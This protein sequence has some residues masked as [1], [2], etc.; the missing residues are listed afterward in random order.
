MVTID[1]LAQTVKQENEK[2]LPLQARGILKAAIA[3]GWQPRFWNGRDGWQYPVCDYDGNAIVLRWKAAPNQGDGNKYSFIPSKP[4]NPLANWYILPGTADAIT[5]NHGVCYLA[6]GEPSK[7]AYHAAGVHNVIATTAS[8]NTVP[9]NTIDVLQKLGVHRLLYPADKDQAGMNSAVKWREALRGSG[10]DYE[11]LQ[12]SDQVP[13][14]GDANDLWIALEFD[15]ILFRATLHNLSPLDLPAVKEQPKQEYTGDTNYNEFPE[16]FVNAVIKKVETLEGFTRWKSNGWGNFSSPFREDKTPSAGFNRLTL[17]YNDFA[18]NGMGIVEFANAIG[19]NIRNYSQKSK[20]KNTSKKNLAQLP[21]PQQPEEETL[22]QKAQRIKDQ[23]YQRPAYTPDITFNARYVSEWASLVKTVK[24]GAIVCI[25]SKKNTGKTHAVD[26]V[27]KPALE[28]EK[29]ERLRSL[30]LGHLRKLIDQY[31]NEGTALSRHGMSKSQL[32]QSPEIAELIHS[33]EKLLNDASDFPEYDIIYW[34]EV[35]KGL[36][37]LISGPM[38]AGGKGI[39]IRNLLERLFKSAKYLYFTDAD[40]TDEVLQYLRDIAPGREII[41]VENEYVFDQKIPGQL[42]TSKR[43][44]LEAVSGDVLANPVKTEAIKFDSVK[45]AQIE[46]EY[47]LSKGID[48]EKILLVTGSNQNEPRQKEYLE[49]PTGVTASGFYAAILL[50]RVGGEGLNQ[51]AP[52]DDVSYIGGRALSPA[53]AAQLASRDRN[54]EAVRAYVPIN[55][56]YEVRS[57]DEIFQKIVDRHNYS[58]IW[59]HPYKREDREIISEAQRDY[60]LM[61]ASMI[62]RDQMERAQYLTAFLHH[63]PQ[64][65]FSQ[66]IDAKASD[67]FNEDWKQAESIRNQKRIDT[68]IKASP[69]SSDMHRRMADNGQT[70]ASDELARFKDH[71][72]YEL[73]IGFE[74]YTAS[75]AELHIN[76]RELQKTLNIRDMM[77]ATDDERKALDHKERLDGTP[78]GN[79]K[80]FYTRTL[81]EN[82]LLEILFDCSLLDTEGLEA[83]AIHHNPADTAGSEFEYAKQVFIKENG[84]EIWNAYFERGKNYSSDPK[85]IFAKLLDKRGFKLIQHRLQT[86]NEKTPFYYVVTDEYKKR[87]LIAQTSLNHQ[88]RLGR[89]SLDQSELQNLYEI[90]FIEKLQRHETIALH[91]TDRN[92]KFPV[93]GPVLSPD[94][95]RTA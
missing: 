27:I 92:A 3:A 68:L 73:G 11:A 39:R 14:K 62:H 50:T 67:A 17:G 71:S 58:Q 44:L 38:I 94:L 69:L 2:L 26:A 32:Q 90:H 45:E 1:S 84:I 28:K 72:L 65:D 30:T 80:Q 19:I 5:K 57:K 25:K 35:S 54:P 52:V 70:Y 20:P 7:L 76:E 42:Y 24:T 51:T 95:I 34:D 31:V 12:W 85:A 43:A 82:R 15:Q 37:A 66:I 75:I 61:R 47:L 9:A 49:D 46:Y 29:G 91:I 36:E 74:G 59:L 41:A 60:E 64:V 10:I 86:G 81:Y 83:R 16:A 89:Y 33:I 40:F 53:S 56:A 88:R 87:L 79:R 48:P 18:G 4:K 13:D 77:L 23:E 22:L 63:M 21:D 8:E 55:E 6:N 93:L 78:V